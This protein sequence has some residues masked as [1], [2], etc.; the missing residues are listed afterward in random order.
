MNRNRV[1]MVVLLLSALTIAQSGVPSPQQKPVGEIMG[2]V[3]DERSE[4]V[5]GAKLHVALRIGAVVAKAIQYF[6]SDDHGSFAVPVWDFGTYF[7]YV[8]K[9]S[10]G[11]PDTLSFYPER[12]PLVEVT[13]E[14]PNPR[15]IVNLGPK[16]A[17]LSGTV[18]DAK[19]GRPLSSAFNLHW[20]D[21]PK[22]FYSTSESPSFRLLVPPRQ[23]ITLD[24]TASGYE[25]WVYNTQPVLRLEPG[26]RMRLDVV[27]ERSNNDAFGHVQ[28][29]VPTGYV[30]WVR[31]RFDTQDGAAAAT[32]GGV[33]IVKV[34]SSGELMTSSPV[35]EIGAREEYLFLSP[36]DSTRP[37]PLDYWNDD[38]MIWGEHEVMRG[39][40]R[41]EIDFFVGSEEQFLQHISKAERQ[42]WVLE[43]NDEQTQAH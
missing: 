20:V 13:G 38:G 39:G 33:A 5:A 36:D 37:I 28:Y 15:V 14:N 1:S 29:L 6:D 40:H 26:A 30:G 27:L 41:S 22:R 7:V 31:I 17:V 11:Y 18:R 23:D 34:P 32:E 10:A 21:Q 25:K 3:V 19:T 43:Q 9:E 8:G 4:P 16:A 42:F 24:V 35:P 12:V 2:T